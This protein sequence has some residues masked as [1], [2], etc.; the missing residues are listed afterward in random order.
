M[1]EQTYEEKKEWLLLNYASESLA[2]LLIIR[3]VRFYGGKTLPPKALSK[4]IEIIETKYSKDEV[5]DMLI[6]DLEDI[7]DLWIERMME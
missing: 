4:I 2:S 1:K 7:G 6:N 3:L 5:A